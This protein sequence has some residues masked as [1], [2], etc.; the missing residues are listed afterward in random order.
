MSRAA[1]FAGAALATTACGNKAPPD[2]DKTTEQP[3]AAPDAQAVMASPDA[4]VDPDAQ[5]VASP[6]GQLDPDAAASPPDARAAPPRRDAATKRIP[7]PK[8]RIKNPYGAPPAR[9]RFV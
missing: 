9:R 2:P 6:D 8:I 4:Q 1:I 3:T 7:P 5:A